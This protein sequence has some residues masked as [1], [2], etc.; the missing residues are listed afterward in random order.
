MVPFVVRTGAHQRRWK[1][2][3]PCLLPLPPLVSTIGHD[4]DFPHNP[5]GRELEPY[6]P[7]TAMRGGPGYLRALL[8]GLDQWAAW[9]AS[10]TAL[11]MRPRSEIWWPFCRAHAR[12]AA[13]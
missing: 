4:S 3:L 1:R 7:L 11:E 13:A 12:I 9:K 2:L 8:A 10:T 6:L 5:S